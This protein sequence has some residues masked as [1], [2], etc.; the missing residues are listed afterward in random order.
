MVGTAITA[1]LRITRPSFSTALIL[2]GFG[3]VASMLSV[4]FSCKWTP[5]ALA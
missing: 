3:S 1:N 4:Y 2:N 5:F